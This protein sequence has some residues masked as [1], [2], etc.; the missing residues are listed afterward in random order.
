MKGIVSMKKYLVSMMI[1]LSFVGCTKNEGPQAKD[2]IVIPLLPY[3]G[4]KWKMSYIDAAKIIG[5]SKLKKLA[6]KEGVIEKGFQQPVEF[7]IGSLEMENI[8]YEFV[9][10]HSYIE[11]VMG[12]T[13]YKGAKNELLQILIQ[14]KDRDRRKSAQEMYA[15]PNNDSSKADEKWLGILESVSTSIG[16]DG[17]KYIRKNNAGT[18]AQSNAV[19]NAWYLEESKTLVIVERREATMDISYEITAMVDDGTKFKKVTAGLDLD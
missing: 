7:K 2:S 18:I 3:N 4:L 19:G 13:P 16:K 6:N 12:K 5:E 9:E 10:M 17:T 15:D 8:S 14:V 1:V 11:A